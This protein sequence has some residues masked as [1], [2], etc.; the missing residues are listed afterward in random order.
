[1]AMLRRVLL[2]AGAVLLLASTAAAQSY[3]NRPI[4]VIVP[5]VPGTGTDTMGRAMVDA[6]QPALGQ[7]MVVEN[8]SGAGGSIGANAVAKAVPDGY[9]L[10]AT[11]AGHA[12]NPAIYK[13]LPFDTVEDFVAVAPLAFQPNVLIIA[14][15]RGLKT[16]QELVAYGKANPG[17]L[18]YGSAGIGSGTHLNAEKFRNAAGGYDAVHVPYRGSTEAFPDIMTGR[19]DYF[20]S[21]IS[22]ALQLIRAGNLLALG[23]SS[24]E[25]SPVLPDVPTTVEA[26]VPNSEFVLWYGLLAPKG[27]PREIVQRL[28]AEVNKALQSAEMKARLGAVGA[29]PWVATS[30]QFHAHI[31]KEVQDNIK[32]AA[33]AGIKPE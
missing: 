15:S 32:L 13:S 26:G 29:T 18:T 22:A 20:F 31:R 5:F 10:L 14:P 25:R 1:M 8:R 24:A 12:A 21:P 23:V 4:K 3:P 30:E 28:H 7:P 33:A 9:T 19:T 11:S 16:V 27:T 2:A 17:K 6:I